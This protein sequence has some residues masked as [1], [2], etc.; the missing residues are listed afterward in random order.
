VPVPA[1]VLSIN[2]KLDATLPYRALA[3]YAISPIAQP[4]EAVESH[5]AFLTERGMVGRVYLC[6]DGINAQ[7]S[8]AAEQ[9]AEY[10]AY[11]HDQL[12]PGAA[13]EP[14]LFKEDPCDELAFPRLRVKHRSLVP[15][16]ELLG[17]GA[18]G[19]VASLQDR[20]RDVSPAEWE[21][22]LAKADGGGEEGGGG[23]APIVLDVRN[24]YEWDVG[25]FDG[26]ARPSPDTFAQSD[27]EAYG[28]PS[29][30]EERA[31][32]P[33]MMYC[34]GGIRCEYFGARLRAAGF[35]KVYK[36]QGGVQHYGNAHAAAEEAPPRWKG[37]LFVFDRR[38]TVPLG[39]ASPEVVGQCVHCGAPTEAFVNCGNIDC[40]KL[41]LV[42]EHCL[43]RTGGFC[44]PPPSRCAS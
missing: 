22:L 30:P 23:G 38:N 39:G 43:P 2:P 3:F 10:R 24:G 25:R 33:V 32:T 44:C 17:G 36:L 20:G 5:R 31:E 41:H 12:G 19:R 34:T 6:E 35:E 16:G 40:N 9:C 27:E 42:C 1:P 8:G 14:I 15:S 37:S 28:L 13:P 26:A 7:V 21:E 29:D 4:D 11:C 18:S